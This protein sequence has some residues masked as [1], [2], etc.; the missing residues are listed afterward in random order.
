MTRK[1]EKNVN[2]VF[3]LLWIISKS[4]AITYNIC[5]NNPVYTSLQNVK[6]YL[7]DTFLRWEYTFVILIHII[8]LSPEKQNQYRFP[9]SNE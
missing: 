9:T 6:I 7:K 1:R 4:F 2:K 5:M 3:R 8:K